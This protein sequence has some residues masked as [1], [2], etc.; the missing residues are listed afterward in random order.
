LLAERGVEAVSVAG[1]GNVGG[2]G[3]FTEHLLDGVSGDQ[4]N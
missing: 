1:G 2:R 3:A 4:M